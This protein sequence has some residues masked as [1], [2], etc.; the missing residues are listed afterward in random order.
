MS[1][2]GWSAF[3]RENSK[4]SESA[5]Y[6]NAALIGMKKYIFNV[7]GSEMLMVKRVEMRTL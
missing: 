1:D 4:T 3:S 2:V 7:N 6:A 5:S